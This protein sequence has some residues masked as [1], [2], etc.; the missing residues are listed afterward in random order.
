MRHV[1]IVGATRTAQIDGISAAGASPG[2]VAHTP[3]A[4]AEIVAF[5]QP[6]RSPMA[7][8]S[9]TGCPTPAVVTRA[10]RE[11]LGFDLL[12]VDTGLITPTAAPTVT[13]GAEPGHDVRE[14]VA[15]PTAEGISATARALGE[16]V[17]D[18]D[19]LI[20]ESIPGGTTTALG[21]LAALGEPY[22][23]SSSRQDNP[24]D[25]K[26]D[27][28]AAGLDASDIE[29]G[30]LAGDPLAAIAAMGDPVFAGLTGFVRGRLAAGRSVTL[31]G[32]TQM[33][34]VAAALRHLGVDEP[35]NVTT[36]SFVADDETA[37]VTAAADALNVEL[38]VIDPRF[39][40]ANLEAL[41]RYVHGEAKEGVGM[42][43]ALARAQD[44]GI[45]QG[46][47]HRRIE[48]C[49]TRLESADGS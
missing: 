16:G 39:E 14:A 34:A 8:A 15:V 11:L 37:D 19:L 27:V 38:T 45:S 2:M 30:D 1:L 24:I 35:L 49:I 28:V 25:R 48:Q 13:A 43:G 4:D 26:T 33:I 18:D 21:V 46:T 44:A 10:V 36:T 5:G 17:P 41:E 42:G 12:T 9:P 32:G 23:V 29:R 47:V 6:V 20:G 31:A 7:P 40:R 3:S 22:M